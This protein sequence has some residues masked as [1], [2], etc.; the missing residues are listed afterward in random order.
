MQGRIFTFIGLTLGVAGAFAFFLAVAI[1]DAAEPTDSSPTSGVPPLVASLVRDLGHD[2]YHRRVRADEQLAKLGSA[3]RAE[4]EAAAKDP[5]PEVRLR[6]K[7][8]LRQLKVED[9]WQPGKFAYSAEAASAAGVLKAMTEQ[10]GNHVLL[11]DQYG[12]FDDRPI[13][14]FY[15]SGEFGRRSMIFAGAQATGCGRTSIRASRGSSFPPASQDFIP[16]R[17]PGRFERKSFRRGGPS[18][19]NSTTKRTGAIRPTR[20]KSTCR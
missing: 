17:I 9:L 3:A 7:E 12:N 16:R 13:D 6:A 4:L 1:S 15:T 19:R 20:F 11:G 2:D 8:L 14:A 5:S 18:A 10:T